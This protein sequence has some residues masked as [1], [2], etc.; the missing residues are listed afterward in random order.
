MKK[1]ILLTFLSITFCGTGYTQDIIKTKSGEEIK[2]MLLKLDRKKAV[3]K[4]NDDPEF[5]TYTIP[6]SK[7]ASIQMKG[8]KKPI[9]FNHK[10]PRAFI[11]ISVGGVL[12]LG[13]FSKVDYEKTKT[14]PGFAEQGNTIAI[15]A[16]FYIFKR[17][18]LNIYAGR[19]NT[20]YNFDAY[21]DLFNGSNSSQTKY[22]AQG[23][24]DEKWKFNYSLI[25]PMYSVKLSK[26]ITW[27]IMAR[28]GFQE[29]IKPSI[30]L[31]QNASLDQYYFNSEP[32]T[33][34]SYNG[35]TNFRIMLSKRFALYLSGNYIR[36]NVSFNTS[37]NS[38][39]QTSVTNTDINHNI[40]A[41]NV[42]AGIAFNF[43]RKGNKYE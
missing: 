20:P 10:L 36:T 13:D 25:G 6:Y 22:V 26:R 30:E 7:L 19:T 14:E 9:Y 42:S 34:F 41:L 29:I 4:S 11:G 28:V 35:G 1:I 17:L 38:S 2:A 16:G 8:E 21:S 23:N 24:G 27:D 33:I 43:K 5:N 12:P 37:V 39:A 18:G 3:Y 32:R 15:E 31:R 40:T